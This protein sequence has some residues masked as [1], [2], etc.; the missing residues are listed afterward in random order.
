M[1]YR[2]ELVE[3]SSPDIHKIAD[4]DSENKVPE[5]LAV[6]D[7]MVLD[8]DPEEHSNR[9]AVEHTLVW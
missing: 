3:S 7:M 8:I 2:K 9:F 6:F 5:I 1:Y 4:M